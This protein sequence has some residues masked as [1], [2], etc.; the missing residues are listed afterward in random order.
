MAL[1]S[2]KSNL[3]MSLGEFEQTVGNEEFSVE[4]LRVFWRH[5]DAIVQIYAQEINK[6]ALAFDTHPPP[7]D[8]DKKSL[9]DLVESA[10]VTLLKT[11]LILP[12][13]SGQELL[14]MAK[15]ACLEIVHS[16]IEFLTYL[17]DNKPRELVLQAVGAVWEKCDLKLPTNN[18]EAVLQRIH[19]HKAMIT[20]ALNELEE[21]KNDGD[22][23]EEEKWTDEELELVKPSFGIIKSAQ[24]ILKKVAISVKKQGGATDVHKI[25]ELDQLL[26]HVA[27][28]SPAVDDFSLTIYHPVD[29]QDLEDNA[30]VVV[31]LCVELLQTLEGKHY[32]GQSD[33]QEWGQFLH[34]A[35]KHN[36]DKLLTNLAQY[37]L[38]QLKV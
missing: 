31:R 28:I 3:E 36:H 15:N 14:K 37:K 38:D 13:Q 2:L 18:C 25:D 32:V 22:D 11:W 29:V 21:A 24:A 35:L 23:D 4:K 6:L 26:S 34:K 8:G 5:F 10:N 17:H 1:K 27:T 7:C 16:T 9:C 20:D 30:Q 33:V 19:E 12:P